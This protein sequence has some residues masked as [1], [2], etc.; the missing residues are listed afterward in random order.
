MSFLERLLQQ[1]AS[2]DKGPDAV[3]HKME[4]EDAHARAYFQE[5][6]LGIQLADL[7]TRYQSAAAPGA[8]VAWKARFVQLYS[9]WTGPADRHPPVVVRRVLQELH[10]HAARFSAM[11]PGALADPAAVGDVASTLQV[12]RLMA[13]AASNRLVMHRS[14]LW[15]DLLPT[16]HFISAAL[17]VQVRPCAR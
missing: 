16:L 9:D 2:T 12:L 5:D 15:E 17:G 10:G 14:G 13:P 4:E 3:H 6:P 7:W 8:F 1:R 11:D